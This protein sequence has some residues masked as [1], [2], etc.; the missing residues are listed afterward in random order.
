LSSLYLHIPF[1]EHKCVYCDFY[2]LEHLDGIGQFCEALAT[3]IE[4]YR[5]FGAAEKVETIFFGG[6]TPS[7]LPLRELEE[8]L[9]HLASVFSIETGAEITLEANPGTIDSEKL[10]AYRSFGIN[11]LSVGVQSFDNDELK[12]LTRVHDA[13]EAKESV[14][15]AREAGFDNINIDLIFALPSQ[16]PARWQETVRQAVELG[17]EHISAYNLIV[18]QGTPLARMVSQQSVQLLPSDE[19]AEMYLWTMETLRRAGYEHYEVS[20]YAKPG[21]ACRHNINYWNH[22]NYIGFGPSA[23]S[24]WNRRRWWNIAN[25]STYFDSLSGRTAPVA[26]EETLTEEQFVDETLMLS[27]RTGALHLPAIGITVRA[28]GYPRVAGRIRQWESEGLLTLDGETIR[29]TDRGYLYC[30]EMVRILLPGHSPA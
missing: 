17:P 20:N 16:T 5:D 23:H 19:E 28:A 12:F 30:D 10:R 11:R 26:G 22:T 13:G 27:L 3:E 25:L 15:R 24:F 4:L 21:R 29:L 2:S 7:L 14:R 6:G 9:R 8:I 1:C 18:E